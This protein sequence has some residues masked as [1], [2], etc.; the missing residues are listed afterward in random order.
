M[1]DKLDG[2]WASTETR[3]AMMFAAAALGRALWVGH[4]VRE[5]KRRWQISLLIYE[6]MM[7]AACW[8]LS[9]AGISLVIRFAEFDMSQDWPL[10]LAFALFVGWLGLHGLQYFVVRAM[11]RR[12]VLSDDAKP[13]SG[14]SA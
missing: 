11:V 10:A 8:I 12:G 4:L 9:L 14:P 2:W 5:G 6:G 13:K 3:L 7:C 1:L